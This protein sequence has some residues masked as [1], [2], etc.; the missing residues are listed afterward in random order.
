MLE[1]L[2]MHKPVSSQA[3][4]DSSVAATL[5]DNALIACLTPR[6]GV[7]RWNDFAEIGSRDPEDFAAERKA[8]D[9]VM[10][11]AFNTLRGQGP[12]DSI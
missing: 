11:L 7:E 10:E 5:R 2:R 4:E 6:A 9:V 12:K 8:S 1:Q 3:N